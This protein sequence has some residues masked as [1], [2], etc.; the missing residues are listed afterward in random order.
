MSCPLELVIA[1]AVERHEFR[2][3]GSDLSFW[4]SNPFEGFK[5]QLVHRLD[6][7]R[8]RVTGEPLASL[9]LIAWK[10]VD[11]HSVLEWIHLAAIS[12]ILRANDSRIAEPSRLVKSAT[13]TLLSG[14]QNSNADAPLC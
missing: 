3:G 8:N 13:A 7:R 6:L 2:L 10:T 12:P 1:R 9:T 14:N 11:V 4:M 5:W